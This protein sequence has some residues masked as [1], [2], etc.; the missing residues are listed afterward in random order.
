VGTQG[1]GAALPTDARYVQIYVEDGMSATTRYVK[2][3]SQII[4][5]KLPTLHFNMLEAV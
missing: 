2:V 1:D 4:R 3:C 5:A